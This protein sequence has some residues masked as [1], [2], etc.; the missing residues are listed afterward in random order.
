MDA[1]REPLEGC[2]K[3]HRH[4]SLQASVGVHQVRTVV[5]R[6][7]RKSSEQTRHRPAGKRHVARE[8]Q[9]G[10][11]VIGVSLLEHVEP[12]P[13]TGDRPTAG[14]LL[15]DS[16]HTV[17]APLRRSDDHRRSRVCRCVQH[18]VDQC[19]TGENDLSLVGPPS[20]RP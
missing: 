4:H 9:N 1:V 19:T 20:R 14:R 16:G 18:A 7:A 2:A 8:D 13:Q 15:Q 17:P 11:I 5:S 12:C 10:G 6:V 3:R